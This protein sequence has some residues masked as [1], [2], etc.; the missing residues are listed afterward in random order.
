MAGDRGFGYMAAGRRRGGRRRMSGLEPAIACS[1]AGR[2]RPREL[3]DAAATSVIRIPDELGWVEAA[4][5]YW[6]VPPLLGL[7]R[8]RR[9]TS[10]MRRSSGSGRWARWASSSWRVRPDASSASIP[11]RLGVA[12]RGLGA[13]T[14]ESGAGPGIGCRRSEAG[15]RRSSSRCRGP[16][17]GSRPRSRSSV[18]RGGSRSS[19]ASSVSP[20]STCSGRSSTAG[21]RS[22]RSG[23]RA[24]RR[25]RAQGVAD[26][27]IQRQ[28]PLVHE[29]LLRGGLEIEPLITWVVPPERRRARWT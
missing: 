23:G 11:S 2:G 15:C 10:T 12:G 28:L 17:P 1:P 19:A 27:P 13:L 20:T 21:Q 4:C 26:S 5:S 7:L 16:S 29:M 22:S 9:R 25:C 8:P 24:P 6:A 14:V 18:R 3:I